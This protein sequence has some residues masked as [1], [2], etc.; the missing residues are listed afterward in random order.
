MI[1]ILLGKKRTEMRRTPCW[2]KSDNF[3]QRDQYSELNFRESRTS[4]IRK[5]R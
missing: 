4:P 2:E 1:D 3:S 5:E